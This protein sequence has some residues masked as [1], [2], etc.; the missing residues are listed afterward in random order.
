MADVGIGQLATVTGRYRSMKLKD[1]VTDSL[2]VLEAM[3]AEGGI[4]RISG[5]RTI[6]DEG[7]TGQNSTV[8]WVGEAGAV[9]L[10]DQKVMDSPEYQWKYLLGAVSWTLAE[11]YQN[12]GEEKYIDLLGGKYQALEASLMNDF[13]EGVLSAGTGSGG[14][15]LGGLALGVSTTPTSGTVG[16]ISRAAAGTTWFQ[17]QKFDT[18]AD[19]ADGAADAGNIKRLLDKGLNLT[20]R[21][22][23]PQ[24]QLGILGQNYFEY[25]T[26]ATQ[27]IQQ[28]VNVSDTGRVGFNKL[29]YRGVPM[30]FGGGVSY[31]GNTQMT[32][33]RAYLL[34]VQPGGVN[35]T[36]HSKAEFAML[37]PVDSADQAARSRLM[38]TMANMTFGPLIRLSIV[39]FD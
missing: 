3:K 34:N 33:T 12:S 4:R 30:Y 28:I 20:T 11:V 9:S 15:Q 10:V 2:P 13:H 35:L 19:W 6:L 31:S 1:A 17:N 37:D 23:K 38:F 18:A 26:Q 25:L 5:G 29:I 7:V 14:L 39:L 16:G 22:G 21:S 24:V 27:A 36:Y 8:A 32:A